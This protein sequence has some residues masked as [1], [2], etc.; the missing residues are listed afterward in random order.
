MAI[1][2]LRTLL[3]R[4]RLLV[5]VSRLAWRYYD[6]RDDWHS[7][8]APVPEEFYGSGC[9]GDFESFL[10][11]TL[12]TAFSTP[13]VLSQW[14]AACT[15]VRDP[16]LFHR[17][18]FW[19]HPRTFEQLRRGDCEDHALFAWR[20]L[21]SL[22]YTAEFVVGFD[23][24]DD[25][26]VGRHAWVL[27]SVEGRQLLFESV[28][29]DAAAAIRPLQEVK[30]SYVPHASVDGELRRRLYGGFVRWYMDSDLR[31]KAKKARLTPGP[32]HTRSHARFWRKEA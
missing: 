31:M 13:E 28:C 22:G 26:E 25:G 1:A 16:D 5:P 2:R 8:E 14:L 27:F 3:T 21:R 20:V 17:P 11:G 12:E 19:Q 32:M 6:E 15:Y 23:R 30:A 4:R 10:D 24:P 18:D 7:V 9:P 29:K